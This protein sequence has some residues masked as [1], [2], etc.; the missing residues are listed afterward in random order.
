MDIRKIG[1]IKRELRFT[2][3]KIVI[4]LRMLSTARRALPDFLVAGAQKGGTTSLFAY[5]RQH[6]SIFPAYRS[7]E[8]HYWDND[9]NY[10][11]GMRW[12]RAHFPLEKELD[13][14]S[15]ITGEKTPNYLENPEYIKQI[16]Q[17]V[18]SVKL[19]ILLR[20]PVQ[21][22]ISNYFM[23]RWFGAEELPLME[24][25]Q[26]EEERF[27]NPWER[28][29]YRTERA[30]KL[31]S[32]YSPSIKA[33]LEHFSPEQL[34]IMDSNEFFKEPY[35]VLEKTCGFLNI[36]FSRMPEIKIHKNKGGY[37]KESIPGEVIN[38]LKEYFRPY[39]EELYSLLGRDFGW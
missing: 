2:R 1:R 17:D 28:K 29:R 11:K 20:N 3:N 12:Y 5:L 22:A 34:L 23:L 8:I 37:D 32:V 24:A 13:A 36:P 9:K 21:R 38:Y 19:I 14:A 35:Q 26:V 15:A 7:K 10:Q 16:K 33:C 25:M 4:S 30:Y 6:P 31:R 27:A 18:P 39:N